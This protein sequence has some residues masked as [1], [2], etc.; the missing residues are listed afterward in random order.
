MS[1]KALK[2]LGITAIDFKTQS[3]TIAKAHK[4]KPFLRID[5]LDCFN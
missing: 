1:K 4:N 5:K 3:L 2:V